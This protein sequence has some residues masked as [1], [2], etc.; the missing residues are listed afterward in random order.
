MKKNLK[1]F[2]VDFYLRCRSCI[3]EQMY[4]N[5]QQRLLVISERLDYKSFQENQ[6]SILCQRV[7]PQSLFR[8]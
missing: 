5:V 6:I 8:Q 2:L 3:I 1:R 7:H 4:K